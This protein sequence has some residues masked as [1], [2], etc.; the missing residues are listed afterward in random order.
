[1]L[2]IARWTP[3]RLQQL[4]KISDAVLARQMGTTPSQV[5]SHRIRLGIP[6]PDNG[7]WSDKE[8]AL[9]GTMHDHDLAK[10]L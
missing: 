2:K 7:N 8:T 6:A 10:R 3:R 1:M 5:K 4:G 9:L